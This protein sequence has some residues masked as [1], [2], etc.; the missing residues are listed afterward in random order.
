MESFWI[1]LQNQKEVKEERVFSFVAPKLTKEELKLVQEQ[2]EQ[3][4]KTYL[5][6]N[7]HVDVEE[8]KKSDYKSK[9]VSYK[10]TLCP[11]MFHQ[12]NICEVTEMVST[13]I[14]KF[15]AKSSLD[16]IKTGRRCI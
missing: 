3:H 15:F 13:V 5:E 4:L 11:R 14:F 7:P 6:P 9:Y 1:N 12:G 8:M 16:K 2:N 10:R